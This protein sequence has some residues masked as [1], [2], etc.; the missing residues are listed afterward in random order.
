MKAFIS[1]KDAPAAIGPYAQGVAVSGEKIV[2]VS[3]QLPI[4][5]KT[6][7]FAGDMI[8]EQTE[9]SIRNIRAV[10]AQAGMEL[11]NVVRTT[12]FLKN[13]DDFAAMNEVYAAYFGAATP[14]R[15]AVEVACLPKN[16]LVEIDAIAVK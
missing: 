8:R 4:D 11:E 7:A 15:S 2:F 12:C 6:G 9:Q 10:L 1:T 14:A 3:G 16:A 5:P 13:M